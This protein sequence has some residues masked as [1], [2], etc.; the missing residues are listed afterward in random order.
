[1]LARVKHTTRPVVVVKSHGKT[2]TAVKRALK[3]K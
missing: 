1:M 2:T 3:I